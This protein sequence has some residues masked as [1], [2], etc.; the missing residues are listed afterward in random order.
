MEAAGTCGVITSSSHCC[1]SWDMSCSA[2][3]SHGM[4]LRA[5][6]AMRAIQYVG[7]NGLMYS[8]P[9]PVAKHGLIMEQS[10]ETLC[11]SD[12][13]GSRMFM[14]DVTPPS[15]HITSHHTTYGHLPCAQSECAHLEDGFIPK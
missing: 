10:D 15:H 5:R 3:T 11:G 9:L 13:F 4:G 12:G 2:H 7:F 6:G 8:M 1:M 14:S